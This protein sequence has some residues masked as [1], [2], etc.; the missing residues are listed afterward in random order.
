MLVKVLSLQHVQQ[1]R[2]CLACYTSLIKCKA[3][4]NLNR[5]ENWLQWNK[6][7]EWAPHWSCMLSNMKRPKP[8]APFPTPATVCTH[9]DL[10]ISRFPAGPH[11]CYRP[12]HFKKTQWFPF[13][14]VLFMSFTPS[15]LLTR[16]TKICV[17][18]NTV[19]IHSI[20]TEKY[21]IDLGDSCRDRSGLSW[22]STQVI[23][24]LSLELQV[25]SEKIQACGLEYMKLFQNVN[26][27]E[28]T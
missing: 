27:N 20:Y 17:Y 11:R 15:L 25:I 6:P 22:F 2:L 1:H 16:K 10:I 13:P 19:I 24:C 26:N 5:I 4:G 7:N 8:A 23:S 21:C 14:K 12:N 18:A 28:L 9:Y 3:G